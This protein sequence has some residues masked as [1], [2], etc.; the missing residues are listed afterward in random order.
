MSLI[1]NTNEEKIWNYLKSKGL[2]DYGCAGMMGNLYAESALQP[3]NVQNGMGFEDNTYTLSVDNGTYSRFVND[4]VGYGL[5]Q[6]TYWSRKQNLLNYA[7]SVGKSIGDLEMQ[8]DFLMKE[9]AESYKSVLNTLKTAT[10]VVDASNDVLLKFERPADMGVKIQDRRAG[11]GQKYYDKYAKDDN[12]SNVIVGENDLRNKV[13]SIAISFLGCK[14]SDGS[15]KQIIDIYNNF[16]PIPVGYKV[17]YTDAWCATYVSAVGIKAGL[18]DIVLRECG[19]NRMI[20]LYKKAGRWVENDAYTPMIGD[21]IFYDWEDNGVGDN[22]GDSDHVGFIVSVNGTTMKIIEGNISDSVGYR[23]LKVNGKYIRGYGIPDYASKIGI[24]GSN[25]N[26]GSTIPTAPSA[27]SNPTISTL[28]YNIGDIVKFTGNTHYTSSNA[29]SPKTCKAGTAK[30]TGRSNGAKHP[31][32]LIAEKG[33]GSTVYGWV[34][35]KDIAEKISNTAG[36]GT[37]VN[38][39]INSNAKVEYAQSFLESLAGAYKTTASLN[40]RAGA[41]TS[42][43]ILTVVPKGDKVNCYGYYTSVNGTRWYY[44]TYKNSKGISFTGFVSSDY[45]KK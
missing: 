6:W 32:H 35:E 2:N 14:E 41:G 11:Y 29:S 23:T 34:D 18:E 20:D 25:D 39:S 16:K 7:K 26:I 4:S 28:K 1:G 31:Y 27:P 36:N 10:T 37:G 19:C 5:A 42:K 40:M 45:L 38:N 3:N 24:V 30:V 12:H 13:V 8:L 33:K 9:L 22:T 17:K 21:V 43:T 15:H 44:I